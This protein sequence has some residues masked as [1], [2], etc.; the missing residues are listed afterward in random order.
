MLEEPQHT[1]LIVEDVNEISSHMSDAL[2]A[3][4]HRILT[5]KNAQD[6]IQIAE[7]DRPILI[8]TDIDLPTFG[9]LVKSIEGHK[10]LN[11]VPVVIVDINHPSLGKQ[12]VKVVADFEELDRL[13]QSLD[14][15]H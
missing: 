2:V 15:W 11:D 14:G 3:K 7:Q 13:I 1:V 5:A 12:K 9:L 4:G 6:A 8:L 10:I